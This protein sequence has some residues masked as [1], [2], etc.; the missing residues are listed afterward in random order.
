MISKT[1]IKIENINGFYNEFELTEEELKFLTDMAK[2]GRGQDAIDFFVSEF[3]VRPGTKYQDIVSKYLSDAS[4]G[5]MPVSDTNKIVRNVSW[6]SLGLITLLS[7][8]FNKFMRDVY[9]PTM[10]KDAALRNADVRKAIIKEVNAKHKELLNTSMFQTQAFVNNGVRTLQRELIA[11]DFGLTAGKISGQRLDKEVEL[12]RAQLRRKY[13]SIYKAME[14]GNVLVSRRFGV[15][16]IKTRHYKMGYY[17]DM[18]VRTTILNARR[19]TVEVTARA[20]GEKVVGYKL[21]DSR[22]VKKPREI[23]I[24]ILNTFVLGKSILALDEATASALGIMTVDEAKT[25]SDFAMGPLCRHELERCRQKYLLRI[26]KL[27]EGAA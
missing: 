23:C 21:A 14:E 25:T 17:L 10:F 22:I 6:L 2:E 9:S 19:N 8:S 3:I 7:S 15:D 26:D 13:P 11:K 27:L 18:A 12:F 24:H 16:A 4:F 1:N 20:V 5:I